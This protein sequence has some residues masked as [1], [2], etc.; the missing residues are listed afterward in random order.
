MHNF[1]IGYGFDLSLKSAWSLVGNFE[2][3]KAIGKGYS[4][5]IYLSAGYVPNDKMKL[6]F[7]LNNFEDT[8]LSLN[9][10]INDFD[11]KISSNYNFLNDTT[12]YGAK[13]NFSK[14][15]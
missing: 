5:E 3:F 15:F 6:G 11:L 1:K 9:N 4:N 10:K 14:R 2:R 8:S 13:I 12:D 7:N